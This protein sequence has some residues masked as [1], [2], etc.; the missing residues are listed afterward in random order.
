M[1][2]E[3]RASL[4]AASAPDVLSHHGAFC[5]EQ[6]M[7]VCGK[8]GACLPW[9]SFSSIMRGPV[10]VSWPSAVLSP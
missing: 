8:C 4:F 3:G 1:C 5:F 10:L 9:V 7:P 6:G 2:P